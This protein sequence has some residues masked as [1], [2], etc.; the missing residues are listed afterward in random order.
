[1]LNPTK[2]LCSKSVPV[3]TVYTK[4]TTSGEDIID[5]MKNEVYG[6]SMQLTEES[7]KDNEAGDPTYEEV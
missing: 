6:L 1:M 3:A 4:R 2:K 7:D 5:T